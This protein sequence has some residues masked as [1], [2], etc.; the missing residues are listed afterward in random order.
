MTKLHTFLLTLAYFLCNL[1]TGHGNVVDSLKTVLQNSSGQQRVEILMNLSQQT[2]KNDPSQSLTY[3]EEA[4]ST[5]RDLGNPLLFAN[6]LNVLAIA[7]Y[8]L[9]EQAVSLRYVLESIDQMKIAL[10]ADSANQEL[11]FRIAV[12]SNNAGN[13]YKDLGQHDNALRL[14]I[15]SEGIYQDL[16]AKDPKERRYPT[17]YIKC[18]NN[19]ALVYQD[20]REYT[21][22]ESI[23]DEALRRSR[24]MNFLQGIAMCLNNLGLLEIEREEFEKAKSTYLDALDINLRLKDSIAIDGTYNNLGLICEKT[25]LYNK[26]LDYYKSSL[27]ISK[28]LK[29]LFGI[30]NTSVNIGKIYTMIRQPDSARIYLFRGLDAAQQGGMLQLQQQSHFQLVEL[31]EVSGQYKESLEAYRDY[32]IIKDSIFNLERSRQIAEMETKY[33]TEKKEAENEI[34]RKDVELNKIARNLLI[35]LVSGLIVIMVLLVF[36]SRYKTRVLKQQT[37]LFE[38]D[39]KMKELALQKKEIE[40]KHFE[41]QVFAEQEINRLQRVKLDEQNRK[42]AAS[43]LQVTAKNQIL[44]TILQEIDQE[45]ELGNADTEA[46]FKRI[47]RTV[48]SNLNLDKDWEQFKRHFEEVHPDFFIRLKEQYPELSPGEQK[49]CAYYRINLGTNEIAQILNVTIGGVQKSRHRLRK[50]LGIDS[51][52]EMAEF[53]LML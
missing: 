3:A 44:D 22:A 30:S 11:Q 36:L 16:L 4:V 12:F 10:A 23:L 31:Y 5:A 6:A 8:Y 52:T 9:G 28:R 13:V 29:Y 45:K 33:E 37:T 25:G 26:A 7:Y 20:L 35:V 34:L 18:L 27:L 15:Q 43:A 47:Q 32:T 2:A 42:L 1:S 46:C 24:E 14:F 38:Q 50:K 40:R 53:M 49:I 17:A 48:K 39:K 21:K 41:D 51:E 19:K